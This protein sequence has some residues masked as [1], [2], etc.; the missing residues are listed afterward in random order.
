ML[1]SM[2]MLL[3]ERERCVDCRNMGG[4]DYLRHFSSLRFRFPYVLRVPENVQVT[5]GPES[6][7]A[8]GVR[9]NLIYLSILSQHHANEVQSIESPEEGA[10]LLRFDSTSD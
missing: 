9:Q 5:D 7:R 1:M 4:D 10:R 3:R 2:L 8:R 6:A